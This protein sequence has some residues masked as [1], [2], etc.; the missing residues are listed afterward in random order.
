MSA[1]SRTDAHEDAAQAAAAL[2]PLAETASR[3]SE[4]DRYRNYYVGKREGDGWMRATRLL[5]ASVASG[6]FHEIAERNGDRRFAGGVV[7]RAYVSSVVLTWA[8]PVLAE[9][10]LPLSSF[11]GASLHIGE[12]R[13]IDSVAVED[14]RVAVLADD[15]AAGSPGTVVLR[16]RAELYDAL[17][18]KL[19]AVEPLL[20]V[21]REVTHLGW[22]ALWGEVADQLGGSALWLAQLYDRDRWAAWDEVTAIIDRLAAREAKLKVRPRPFPVEWS[23]GVELYQVRGT[24]CLYYRKGKAAR[25]NEELYCAGCPIR[26]DDWRLERLRAHLE[27]EASR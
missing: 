1:V 19:T 7:S 4:L 15:P 27:G 24:C 11:E 16:D 26:S 25:A 5:D 10:R 13:W 21:V 17:V 12:A 14:E 22:P 9:A 20:N 3:I 8:Y 23:G 6:W 18:D 2:S